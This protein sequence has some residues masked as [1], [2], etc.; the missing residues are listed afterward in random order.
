MCYWPLVLLTVIC[1]MFYNNQN[2]T[3]GMK[4]SCFALRHFSTMFKSTMTLK[5][6]MIDFLLTWTE[7]WTELFWIPVVCLSVNFSHF[8]L[9]LKNYCANITQ[10]WHNLGWREFKFVKEEAMPFSKGSNVAH[11]PLDFLFV[12]CVAIHVVQDLNMW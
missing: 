2:S 1:K 9:L 4:I 8:H 3:L 10:N 7:S 6:H 5:Y 11:G 12:A